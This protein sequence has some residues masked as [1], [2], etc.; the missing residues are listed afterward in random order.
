MVEE[1]VVEQPPVANVFQHPE[2]YDYC[3]NNKTTGLEICDKTNNDGSNSVHVGYGESSAKFNVVCSAVGLSNG[4]TR[5]TW[6]Y[7]NLQ[8]VGNGFSREY[9]YEFSRGLCESKYGF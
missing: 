4:N 8:L 7:N 6:K 3:H 9:V 1:Q 5:I 2:Y